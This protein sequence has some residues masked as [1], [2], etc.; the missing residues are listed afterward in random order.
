M[1]LA[2]LTASTGESITIQFSAAFL[3]TPGSGGAWSLRTSDIR[4]SL[5]VPA[6][7]PL[8]RRVLVRLQARPDG[9]DWRRELEFA[10]ESTG[11][12]SY[13]GQLDGKV[14][15]RSG[16]HGQERSEKQEIEFVLIRSSSE[17]ALIDPI[18]QSTRFQIDLFQAS[19]LAQVQMG[20]W[21]R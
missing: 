10:L 9:S 2:R 1:S 13:S 18:N 8:P 15:I 4:V 16:A 21:P 11:E 5:D 17:E 14:L 20:Q 19:G 6:D 3:S 12:R 7:R